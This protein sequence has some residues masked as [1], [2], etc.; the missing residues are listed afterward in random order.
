MNA[1]GL[2]TAEQGFQSGH[3]VRKHCLLAVP[4]PTP[5]VTVQGQAMYRGR[6]DA[7]GLGSQQTCL[8]R[9]PERSRRCYIQPLLWIAERDGNWLQVSGAEGDG[10]ARDGDPLCIHGLGCSFFPG[11]ESHTR[12]HLQSKASTAGA[13]QGPLQGWVLLPKCRHL[14]GSG[15]GEGVYLSGNDRDREKGF[16]EMSGGRDKPDV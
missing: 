2:I 6:V 13:G 3:G 14:L 11:R 16:P 8:S 9:I 10:W 7:L 15:V 5:P 1:P 12:I 4:A